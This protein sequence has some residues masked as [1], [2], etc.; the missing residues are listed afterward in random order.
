MNERGQVTA[1]TDASYPETNTTFTYDENGNRLTKTQGGIEDQYDWDTRN[2]LVALWRNDSL[3]ARY[4]YHWSGLRSS[5]ETFGPG[6]SLV[7]FEYEGPWLVAESNVLGNTL[8]RYDRD[9]LGR[10]LS[11]RRNGQTRGVVTDGIGTPTALLTRDGTTVARF[12]Y[13]VWGNQLLADGPE[14]DSMPLRHAGHYFD[15]ESGLYYLGARYYDPALGAF[16]SEDPAEGKPEAPISFNPYV[17]FA[18]N[19]A[20]YGDPDGRQYQAYASTAEAV[21]MARAARNPDEMRAGMRAYRNRGAI[22]CRRTSADRQRARPD[23]ATPTGSR[24]DPARQNL[25]ALMDAVRKRQR[26]FLLCTRRQIW[27]CQR[28][29][30][31]R[32]GTKG[33]VAI[34]IRGE[35]EGAMRHA[36]PVTARMARRLAKICSTARVG[37]TTARGEPTCPGYVQKYPRGFIRS[38]TG[39][40]PSFPDVRRSTTS[41]AHGRRRRLPTSP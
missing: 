7:R 25:C 38:P 4:Y 13:D 21:A 10:P 20:T 11:I 27:R 15:A 29:P 34:R 9:A 24:H 23:I 3:I 17:A 28:P 6:A 36:E 18:A 39:S 30:I 33:C 32:P 26:N 37:L 19:P 35:T 1:I 22:H 2:R 41:S 12:R 14:S 8:A 5:K 16:I 40:S 31:F